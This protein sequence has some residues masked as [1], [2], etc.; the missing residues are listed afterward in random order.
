MNRIRKQRLLV[1]V[2]VLAGLAITIGFALYALRQNIDLFYS[3]EQ[4]VTGVAPVGQ[5][6]RVGGLVVKGSVKR[7]P[8]T[9]DVQFDLTDGAG[10][11]TVYYHGIL[12]DLFREGQGIVADGV[13]ESP[14][15][16]RATQVLAKHDATYMPPGVKAALKAAHQ[17]A[18]DKK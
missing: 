6:M 9:L 2:I 16:F 11:F 3:P 13:L 17:S 15:T 10:T 7:N 4:V 8:E 5:K 1:I 12:P 14:H 18:S